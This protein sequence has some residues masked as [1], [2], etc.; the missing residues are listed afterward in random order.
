M[1]AHTVGILELQEKLPEFLERGEKV[2]IVHQGEPV[3]F[4]VP[5]VTHRRKLPTQAQ[6]DA[7]DEDTRRIEETMASLGI[8]EEDIIA[9]I[10]KIRRQEREARRGLV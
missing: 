1:A 10:E 2:T 7:F 6:L 3:A 4:V 5:A 8:T 9:D